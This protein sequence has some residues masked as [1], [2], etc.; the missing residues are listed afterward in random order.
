MRIS[1]VRF[2]AL[3]GA[4]VMQDKIDRANNNM[5]KYT[6]FINKKHT[7]AHIVPKG[8]DISTRVPIRA[9]LMK[10]SDT[11]VEA[12]LYIKLVPYLVGL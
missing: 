10:E 2:Y 11:T 9:K 4:G 7:L 3:S 12:Y 6:I 1:I 8:S 5:G